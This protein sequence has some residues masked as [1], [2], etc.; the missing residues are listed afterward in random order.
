MW[1][2]KHTERNI[3]ETGLATLLEM[4]KNIQHP[5]VTYSNLNNMVQYLL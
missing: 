2:F 3:A 1:A 5:E 4:I